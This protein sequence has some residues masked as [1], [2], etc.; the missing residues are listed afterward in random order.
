MTEH[1]AAGRLIPLLEDWCPS[2]T[3]F[4]LY[5]PSRRQVPRAVEALVRFLRR[6]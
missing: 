6:S 2:F 3:G 4:Y 5:Y 1:L